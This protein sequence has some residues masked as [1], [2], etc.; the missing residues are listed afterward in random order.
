MKQK[1]E[2]GK[3][4]DETIYVFDLDQNMSRVVRDVDS[5]ESPLWETVGYLGK[6]RFDESTRPRRSVR[7]RWLVY[8]MPCRVARVLQEK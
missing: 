6:R 4:Q 2:K 5:Q 1:N 8:V 3:G 7:K